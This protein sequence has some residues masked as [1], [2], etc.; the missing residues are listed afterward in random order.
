MRCRTHKHQCSRSTFFLR[1]LP[2]CS[3]RLI[4]ESSEKRASERA[5]EREKEK[6]A[7]NFPENI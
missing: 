1:R 7:V 5:R 4:I 2:Y 6:V 3:C